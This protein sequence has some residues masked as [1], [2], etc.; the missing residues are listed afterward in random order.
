MTINLSISRANSINPWFWGS[1]INVSV[2]RLIFLSEKEG[3]TVFS[4][5][6]GWFY[7]IPLDVTIWLLANALFFDV[8]SWIIFSPWG[9]LLTILL[10]VNV[11]TDESVSMSIAYVIELLILFPTILLFEEPD[12]TS[13]PMPLD[14]VLLNI[15]LLCDCETKM[16]VGSL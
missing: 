5:A 7:D 11:F 12:P 6:G 10:E 4:S 1:M 2:P 8:E 13:I 16:P 3:V 9:V 14:I 15:W